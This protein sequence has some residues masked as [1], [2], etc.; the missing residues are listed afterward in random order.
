MSKVIVKLLKNPSNPKLKM[1]YVGANEY[2]TPRKGEDGKLITGLDEQ[3]IDILKISDTKVRE[4]KQ[5]DII[6][7]RK[8]LEKVLNVSLATDSAF[9]EDFNVVLS[10]EDLNLD[11]SNA[12][13]RLIE[14]W[15]VANKK[16]A[17]SEEAIDNDEEYRNC[18]FYIYREEEETSKK[19]KK[20]QNTDEAVAKLFGLKENPKKLQTVASYVLG[21]VA[22]EFTPEQAYLKLKEYISKDV[23]NISKF[24]S[25]VEETP[26]KMHTKLI[27]DKAVK[28]KIVTHIG[29]VYRRGDI[30]YGY[31]YD[32]ALS[33][34]GSVEN[35]GELGSL[36]KEVS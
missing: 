34:L 17:P 1:K 33:Y 27:L 15:L 2:L 12:R 18:V 36:Q 14:I 35:T 23:D 4:A 32:E 19:A 25:S 31:N 9:W 8:D 7:T 28:K 20:E 10:D 30:I 16:A 22:S 21:A 13:D 6:K 29:N 5:K 3:A 11:S 26:E 24:L